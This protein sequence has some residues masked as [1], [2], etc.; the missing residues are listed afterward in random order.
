MRIITLCAAALLLAIAPVMAH[1]KKL[2]IYSVDTPEKKA[3][4]SFDAAWG[5][6]DTDVLLQILRDNGVT[7]TFFLCGT[8]LDD[9]PDQVR[10]IAAE[11]HDI[12]NHGNKHKHGAQLDLAGNKAEIQ[13]CHDKILAVTGISADLFRPPYGEYNDTVLKAAEE[14][15]Y[16]TIQW[17]VETHSIVLLT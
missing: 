5:A 6:D 9:H 12:A 15:G 2:P 4:I 1:A 7:T 16:F 13:N 10:K 17:D 3:S 11:G 8:W 14:L